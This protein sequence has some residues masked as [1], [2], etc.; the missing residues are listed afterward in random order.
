M[1]IPLQKPVSSSAF[2]L[3]LLTA[4]VPT[5]EGNDAIPLCWQT[6]N[7]LCKWPKHKNHNFLP[8]LCW[9]RQKGKVTSRPA[10]LCHEQFNSHAVVE[11]RRAGPVSKWFCILMHLDLICQVLCLRISPLSQTVL[12][13]QLAAEREEWSPLQREGIKLTLLGETLLPGYNCP[14]SGH[15]HPLVRQ[16]LLCSLCRNPSSFWTAVIADLIIDDDGQRRSSS[17]KL[18]GTTCHKS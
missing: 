6:S 15:L 9:P 2:F 11:R 12:L 7:P 8:T 1:N 14:G 16:Q 18:T 5:T 10:R 17:R 13:N 3:K 4:V